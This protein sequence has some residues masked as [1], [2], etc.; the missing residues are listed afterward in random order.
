MNES[1]KALIRIALKKSG[2]LIALAVSLVGLFKDISPNW[3][4]FFITVF[5]LISISHILRLSE[6]DRNRLLKRSSE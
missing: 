3:N 6:K 4:G 2:L 5:L 1:D